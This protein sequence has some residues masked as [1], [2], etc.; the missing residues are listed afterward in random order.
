MPLLFCS[1]WASSFFLVFCPYSAT[2]GSQPTCSLPWRPYHFQRGPPYHHSEPTTTAP[3][4]PSPPH[5]SPH[6]S[7]TPPPSSSPPIHPSSSPP[8]FTIPAPRLPAYLRTSLLLHSLHTATF[9]NHQSSSPASPSSPPTTPA[10][11]PP[12]HP[13]TPLSRI[14]HAPRLHT[15]SP[16]SPFLTSTLLT[17]VLSLP[18]HLA[19]P[20]SFSLAWAGS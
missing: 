3:S 11:S 7:P 8:V 19:L 10:R 16:S 17:P 18:P 15:P 14:T 6:H 1:P 5:N 2:K 13:H 4:H 12:P 20:Q 9:P